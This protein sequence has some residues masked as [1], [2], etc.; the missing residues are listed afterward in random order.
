[1]GSRSSAGLCL[2]LRLCLQEELR[3]HMIAA[4]TADQK[5][6]QAWTEINKLLS[7][8]GDPYTRRIE[9]E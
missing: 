9:P 1:M 5:P 7:E 3:Q 6:E 2:C 8:L 4:Y